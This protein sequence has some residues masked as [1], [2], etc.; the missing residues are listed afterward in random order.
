M[1]GAFEL[2]FIMMFSMPVIVLGMNFV[3]I[4]MSYNQARY[5]QDYTI[6]TIEHQN[7]L[8]D[9]VYELIQERASSHPELKLSVTQKDARFIVSVKF[10]VEIPLI[11][12]ASTGLVT[13]NTQIIR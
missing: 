9:F 13:T 3:Q 12:Y 7:R 2:G 5:L 11:G 6:S 1:K 8:D 4:M 10:P